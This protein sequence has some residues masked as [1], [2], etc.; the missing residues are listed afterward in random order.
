MTSRATS[1]EHSAPRLPSRSPDEVEA[2]F[3]AANA[4]P[5]S[6]VDPLEPPLPGTTPGYENPV[7]F[8]SPELLSLRIVN[9][10]WIAAR[11][12]I[13]LWTS[14]I[15]LVAIRTAKRIDT[16][17]SDDSIA[18][19]GDDMTIV[20]LVG[21]VLLAALFVASVMWSRTIAEN[22]RR[23]RGRWPSLNRATR[24]WFY[25]TVWVALAALTFLRIKDTGEFNPLPA[26]AAI[27]FAICLYCPY[28]MLHRVFKTLTRVRPDGAIRAAYIL[29]LAGFGILWWRLTDWPDPIT[30]ADSGIVDAMAWAAIASSGLLLISAGI[31][32]NLAHQAIVAQRYRI[33]VLA[34]RHVQGLALPL[35]PRKAWGRVR[36]SIDD[37]ATRGAGP[38]GE[39]VRATDLVVGPGGVP[40]AAVVA[41]RRTVVP[42]R[43]SDAE[44]R[45]TTTS[46]ERPLPRP[47]LVPDQ[48]AVAPPR[49]AVA[50]DGEAPTTE[51]PA[52]E[53]PAAEAPAAEAPAAEAPAAEAPATEGPTTE[54]PP[55]KAPPTRRRSVPGAA[56]QVA[57]RRRPPPAAGDKT[58]AAARVRPGTAQPLPAPPRSA[59]AAA[60]ARRSAMTAAAAARR[61]ATTAAAA[62][63]AAAPGTAAAR[64][65]T[66]GAAGA[67][68]ARRRAAAN[69]TGDAAARRAEVAE[70][71]ARR[72]AASGRAVDPTD[73]SVAGIQPTAGV[74]HASVPS[75]RSGA[76]RPV[77]SGGG[78]R[79]STL[80][81]HYSA[82][83]V[84]IDEPPEPTTL[85]GVLRFLALGAHVVLAAT[86][87]WFVVEARSATPLPDGGGLEPS[88]V[89]RLDLVRTTNVVVLA[90]TVLLIGAWG[91][92]TSTRARR[93][94]RAAPLPWLVIATCVPATLLALI[95]L[96]VDRRVGEGMIFT[97][98]V[99]AAG[100]GGAC[101]LA[102]MS[103]MA[104]E[105][106]ESSHGLQIWAAVIA[107]VGLG[108]TIGGYLQPIEP[109]ESVDTLTLIAVLT[110]IL[111]G[112][113]VLLGAPASGELDDDVVDAR[114]L[115]SADRNARP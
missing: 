43:G 114:P 45:T 4:V 72:R 98:A 94:D 83:L 65:F 40:S 73:E 63:R 14:A 110:S 9:I 13:V 81:V 68:V 48:A 38:V 79:D 20:V 24:V 53:A 21:V 5:K 74:P 49:R 31:T 100:L 104:R 78:G 90:V 69:A 27:V 19:A 8:E 54:A 88:H 18:A 33:R 101:S 91:Y 113:A 107:V 111:V 16:A 52:A 25:P 2:A 109:D 34:T 67:A 15:A 112:L 41:A 3:V 23:L 95:G 55:T 29:D 105:V 84:D 93:S 32:A 89:D 66:P 99:L 61:S 115:V 44:V 77:T 96:V 28:S 75:S 106:D 10:A 62:R 47:K 36:T 35:V 6:Q 42:G 80:D 46:G 39:V 12:A 86:F 108:L 70:A 103:I 64:R 58:G 57:A 51:A 87:V 71:A 1:H 30:A 37:A 85:V 76:D 60:A 7:V 82:P 50:R 22:T 26:I 97:L 11:F 102:L 17:A 59:A 56:G 92:A